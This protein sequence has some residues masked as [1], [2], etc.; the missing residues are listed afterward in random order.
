MYYDKK[1]S[2]LIN[3]IFKV[4]ILLFIIGIVFLIFKN[5]FNHVFIKTKTKVN[6]AKNI[7]N[8]RLT[9]DSLKYSLN[10]NLFEFITKIK[11]LLHQMLN[12]LCLISLVIILLQSNSF[13]HLMI[14]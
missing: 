4:L 7:I 12:L 2:N 14:I 5:G 9:K 10:E 6:N 13:I 1:A 8:D 3:D 11:E